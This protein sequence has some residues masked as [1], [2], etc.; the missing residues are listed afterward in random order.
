MGRA[1]SIALASWVLAALAL[2][3]CDPTCDPVADAGSGAQAGADAG[4]RVPI[5]PYDDAL[6]GF[7][8]GDRTI[9]AEAR[10][11]DAGSADAGS[12]DPDEDPLPPCEDSQELTNQ[13][14]AGGAVLE[15]GT[16]FLVNSTL[17]LR[18]GTLDVRRGVRLE[19]ATDVG[20]WVMGPARMR[21]AGTQ[22]NPVVFTSQDPLVRWQ[23]VRMDG[24]QG[25]DNDWRHLTIEN[26]GSDNW[27]GAAWSAAALFLEG[28]TTLSMSH[29]TIA[30]SEAHGLLAL[31]GVRFS[32][33][34]GVLEGNQT[35]AYLHP[36]VVQYLGRDV[37]MADNADPYV[38]VTFGNNDT[39]T[40]AATWPALPVPYRIEVR[41]FI[42]ADLV[43]EP[44]TVVELSQGVGLHVRDT[45]SLTARGTTDDPI[46]FR[47]ASAG[48]RGYWKGITVESVSGSTPD[49]RG[50]SLD[51][52]RVEDAGSDNWT[53]AA[54]SAAAIFM[55]ATSSASITNTTF[56]NSGLYALWASVNARL[57]GFSDN[58]FTGNARVMVLHPD[59]IGELAGTST[60]GGNDDDAI[61]CTRSNNDS[62]GT[63]AT[64][65]NL[66]VPYRSLS[67]MFVDAGLTLEA[68][69]TVRFPQDQGMIVRD[70]GSLTTQGTASEPVVLTGENQVAG[71]YW[72]GVRIQSN[73]PDNLLQ[74]SVLSYTGSSLW[75]GNGE[76]AAGV[77]LDSGAQVTLRDVTLGPG[78]G[79]GVWIQSATTTLSCDGVSF[80]DLQASAVYDYS[81]ASFLDACP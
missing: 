74:Q 45:G 81:M 46:V 34:A 62:V 48:T 68:G 37:S 50:L 55:N 36:N 79:H 31:D 16:C 3:A 26:A 7:D 21:V 35:P 73:S 13:D 59:R 75:T 12:G 28:S 72:L 44:G 11:D 6:M 60:I 51:H 76:S 61:D 18:D 49:D 1:H 15:E 54:D 33:E 17:V 39:V 30:G 58:T 47:G 69:V 20:L 32:F 42:D 25:V 65:K 4:P 52:A 71:G 77:F 40:D 70:T 64:W 2:G 10:D 8:A 29:V 22:V 5:E 63:D 43:L 66:G 57:D 27:T 24:S 23:G 80:V 38:R 19:F 56:A 41:T 78:G 53:G 9:Y 14:I 67:R